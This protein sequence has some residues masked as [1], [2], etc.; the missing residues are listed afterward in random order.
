M[1]NVILFEKDEKTKEVSLDLLKQTASLADPYTG[2]LPSSRPI[3]H[4][5]FIEEIQEQVD[6][7]N[8]SFAI[9]P[10]YIGKGESKKIKQLDPENK[11]IPGSYLFQPVVTKLN[12]TTPDYVRE[13]YST[14]IAIGYTEKGVQVAF[15]TNVHVC[16]NMCIFG[17][18]LSVTY[19]N[20][21]MPFDKLMELVQKHMNE[22]PSIAESDFG[23]LNQYEQLPVNDRDI[24]ETIGEMQINA[25]QGAYFGGDA[26]LNIGQVSHFTKGI[27]GAHPNLLD[28][29]GEERLMS[30]YDFYNMGTEILHPKRSEVSTVWPGVAHWGD[31]LNNRFNIN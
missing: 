29:G 16:S 6:K 19:G 3:E 23:I 24:I 10:I 12:I 2:K 5:Q 13:N 20:N 11:G 18:R 9:E 28:L 22:L 26:P 15:G 17:G 27:I 21:K 25:V 14:S 1:E 4:W 30:L 7:K 8:L 31:Y